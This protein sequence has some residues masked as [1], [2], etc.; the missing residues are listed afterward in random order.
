MIL[1]QGTKLRTKEL[2]CTELRKNNLSIV[3][4]VVFSS[5]NIRSMKS[6]KERGAGTLAVFLGNRA[7]MAVFPL[8]L[9]SPHIVTSILG[10]YVS[11]YFFFP[12]ICL[13]LAMLAIPSYEQ[14]M[15]VLPQKT[16]IVGIVFGVLYLLSFLYNGN[17]LG[18]IRI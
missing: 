7:A 18:Y 10:I 14:E 2:S 1:N 17:N 15:L 12:L 11:Q 3:I 8:L 4:V 5:Q 16:S 9:L 6:D 13:P